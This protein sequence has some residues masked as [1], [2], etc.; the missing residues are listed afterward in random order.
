[1][2]A[3]K[4]VTVTVTADNHTHAGKPVAKG[5][6]L[7]VDETTAKWLVDNRVAAPAAVADTAPKKEAK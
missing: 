5:T 2:N 3:P 1:M 7:T 6:P 4:Q